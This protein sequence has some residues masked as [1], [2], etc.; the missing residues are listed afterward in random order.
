LQKGKPLKKGLALLEIVD[1][2]SGPRCQTYP[3]FLGWLIFSPERMLS[4]VLK[5]V[6]GRVKVN[7]PIHLWTVQFLMDDITTFNLGFS[8]PYTLQV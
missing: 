3:R 4:Q 1:M 7:W 6:F 5:A 8:I 2:Q